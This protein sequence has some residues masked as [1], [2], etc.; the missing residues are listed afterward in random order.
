MMEALMRRNIRLLYAF[1]LI[2]YFLIIMPVIVPFF[3]DRGLSQTQIFLL[4]SVIAATIVILELPSGYFADRLGRKNSMFI[5]VILSCLAYFIYS[6]D[7]NFNS[8]LFA[9]LIMGA[10]YSFIS[11]A[12]SAIAYESFKAIKLERKYLKY[13]SRVISSSAISQVLASFIGGAL[14]AM[15]LHYATIGQ[16]VIYLFMIPCVVLLCEPPH[17]KEIQIHS[18]KVFIQK[19]KKILAKRNN[20][21][22]LILY[23][24]VTGNMTH[25]L[26]WIT[27]PLYQDLGITIEWFGILW[28]IQYL[29]LAIFSRYSKQVTDYFGKKE[30]LIAIILIGVTSYF[31]IYF[32][33]SLISL[34][35]ILILYAL[36]GLFKPVIIDLLNK[37]VDSESR[38]TAHSIENLVKKLFYA[39][40]GPLIGIS[41]D[42]YSVKIAFLVSGFIYLVLGVFASY[43]ILKKTSKL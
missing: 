24:T 27:Q 22:W 39:F 6:L 12:D 8:L 11:G 43:G 3:Q 5:G 23:F 34:I 9:N 2:K 28:A 26:I 35:F 13:E 20:T 10:G 36:R 18:L 1:R 37:S 16:F 14:G 29:V 31:L 25:T 33:N 30:S 7:C 17:S 32:I 15:S 21:F 4:E 40:L 42:H 38:A 41:L 19:T